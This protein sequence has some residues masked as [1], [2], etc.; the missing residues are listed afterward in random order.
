MPYCKSDYS[1][2]GNKG[3]AR[4]TQKE[5]KNAYIVWQRGGKKHNNATGQSSK[6]YA[7]IIRLN[8]ATQQPVNNRDSKTLQTHKK[9]RFTVYLAAQASP[10]I[11]WKI[12]W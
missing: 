12:Q 11:K 8:G 6:K 3:E 9:Q 1:T 10:F 7:D 4:S 2:K 5:N